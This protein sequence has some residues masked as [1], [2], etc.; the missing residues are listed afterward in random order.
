MSESRE[1]R[2]L[3]REVSR[4][5]ALARR[6]SGR[7]RVGAGV[8]AALL[9]TAPFG[10]LKAAE[11]PEADRLVA[12]KSFEVG[13]YD[14]TI[15]NVVTVGD[16][17]PSI[18]PEQA[19]G[20]LLALRATVTN[21]GD[22]P[23]FAVLVT[24]AFTVEGAGLVAPQGGESP[25]QLV[26]VEDGQSISVINP[27]LTYDVAIVFEQEQGWAEQP[28]TVAVDGYE[29]Q[30]QDALTLDPQSW[31]DTDEVAT[32]GRFDVDVRP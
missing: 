16:L 27:G 30:E 15:R 13:P 28:V 3:P 17:A 4:A 26:S 10:G 24:R 9:V 5:R 20:R 7:Q 19:G 6:T 32:R 22:R 1:V 18:E 12:G 29:F 23:E 31:L 8:A 14:V 25:A 21:P 11:A 2:E